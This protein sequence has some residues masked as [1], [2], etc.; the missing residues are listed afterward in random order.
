MTN[1]AQTSR[2]GAVLCAGWV[3]RRRIVHIEFGRVRRSSTVIR[4][5]TISSRIATSSVY[6]RWSFSCFSP[7]TVQLISPSQW[8]KMLRI[9][10]LVNRRTNVTH[11]YGRVLRESTGSPWRALTVSVQNECDIVGENR[12]RNTSICMSSQNL[13]RLG[14]IHSRSAD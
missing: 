3:D 5:D 2:V 10:K 7:Q 4:S 12:V 1:P 8:T 9:L 14:E 11:Q 6:R 13:R